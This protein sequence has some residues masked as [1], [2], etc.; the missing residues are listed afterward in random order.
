MKRNSDVLSWAPNDYVPSIRTMLKGHT[1]KELREEFNRLRDIAQ[2]RLKRLEASEFKGEQIATR[3]QGGFKR[4][5][6]I[7]NPAEMAA[8]LADMANFIAARTSTVGG[9]RRAQK[10]TL[11]SLQKHG[12]GFINKGNLKA[13]GDFMDIVRAKELAGSVFDSAR[14]YQV[15]KFGHKHN[16]PSEVL[17]KNFLFW[18]DRSKIINTVDVEFTDHNDWRAMEKEWEVAFETM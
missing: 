10:K 13:F 14:L 12:Y 4:L 11:Q 6:D 8:A 15:F 2:K 1:E 16:I 9:Q 17:E 7:R 5:R 18:Y 3:H